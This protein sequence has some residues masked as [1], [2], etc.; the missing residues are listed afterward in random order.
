[1]HNRN[2]IVLIFTC[3]LIE[4]S[5]TFKFDELGKGMVSL[6]SEVLA[7]ELVGVVF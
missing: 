4:I 1:M 5:V 6:S 7:F 2:I 3:E